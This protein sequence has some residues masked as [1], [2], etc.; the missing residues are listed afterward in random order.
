MINL[1]TVHSPKGFSLCRWVLQGMQLLT[2]SKLNSRICKNHASPGIQP[3]FSCC[4]YVI[5]HFYHGTAD[6]SK[7]FERADLTIVSLIHWEK[8]E[9]TAWLPSFTSAWNIFYIRIEAGAFLGTLDFDEPLFSSLIFFPFQQYP[10]PWTKS[11][12]HTDLFGQ[13]NI[14][15]IKF[16]S[17][18]GI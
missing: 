17:E 6:F 5:W 9:G 14:W 10:E 13:K 8:K 11:V 18:T 2:Q 1:F 4:A 7:D 12:L 16:W 15:I 3:T